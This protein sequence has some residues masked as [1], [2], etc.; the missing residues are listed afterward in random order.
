MLPENHERRPEANGTASDVVD[1]DLS[2]L[3]RATLRDVQEFKHTR[4]VV[5]DCPF[6]GSTHRHGWPYGDDTIGSRRSHCLFADYVVVE[7]EATG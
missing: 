1:R 7:L 5:V 2:M 4:D 6:C 3:P